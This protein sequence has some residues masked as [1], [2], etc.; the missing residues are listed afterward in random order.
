MGFL[1]IMLWAPVYQAAIS[2]DG[3]AVCESGGLDASRLMY[4]SMQCRNLRT[5]FKALDREW[6]RFG[7][8]EA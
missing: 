5:N 2:Y 8:F 4:R 7:F 6:V 3:G 1:V